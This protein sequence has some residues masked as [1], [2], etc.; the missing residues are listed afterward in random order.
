MAVIQI[1]KLQV[2][3]GQTAQTGFPQLSS[4]ELGW[5]ID[6]QQLY[7][8]NGSVAEGAPAVGNTQI[9]T[10]NNVTNFFKFANTS[11]TYG[12]SQDAFTGDPIYNVP[13]SVHR[14]IQNKLDDF[15]NL[16]DFGDI[17]S[18][19]DH[20]SLIQ[21][22]INYAA[23][24]AKGKPLYFPE[25]TY[26]VTATIYI[27]PLTEIRGA[28]TEKTIIN[29][30]GY[31]TTF[32]TV[33]SDGAQFD[34]DGGV[35]LSTAQLRPKNIRINGITFLNTNTNTEPMLQLDCVSDTV[36]EQCEFL[37]GTSDTAST[38]SN[39]SPSA[40][41]IRD[42]AGFPG[43]TVDNLAIKNNKFK[44]LSSAV[45]SD[46]SPANIVMSE[47]QL[48]NLDMGVVL[49]MN[50]V[51][52]A[53]GAQHVQLS[54][55]TFEYINNQA[56]YVG[57]TST[58]SDINSVNNWFYDV[59]N[60]QQ[61]DTTSTQVTEVITFN[62]AGNYSTGDTF[63]RLIKLNADNSYVTGAS[64]VQSIINGPFIFKTKAPL[65]KTFSGTGTGNPWFSFPRNTF[66]YGNASY[67]QTITIDYTIT[68]PYISLIKRGTLEVTVDGTTTYVKDSS[69]ANDTI[70]GEK[71]SFSADVNTGKNLVTIYYYNG[72]ATPSAYRPTVIY[73]YTV[74]Q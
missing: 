59:G 48:Y 22:A 67:N 32:Q 2:R 6:T 12:A 74:R 21:T 51:P 28:G 41:N 5:S 4:G 14:S 54:N 61:G 50:L 53:V 49:G 72:T 1:S 56:I 65:V 58:V 7:I 66:Q 73:T 63:D 71:I 8:G 11:Y 34:Q 38:A 23:N 27:P 33:S 40:I 39:I 16:S 17:T 47:N 25:Y 69:T 42:V 15:I 62:N 29:N 35:A 31:A 55:N 18:A 37:G 36:I 45:Y 64:S 3:R 43:N 68:C 60:M 46:Y 70:N 20:T 44:Q 30:I 26:T 52:G 24:T 19:T 9:I 13:V 10:E 57:S